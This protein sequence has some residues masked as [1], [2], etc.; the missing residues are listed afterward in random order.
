MNKSPPRFGGQQVDGRFLFELTG[1]APALNFI[2]TLDERR[3]GQVERLTSFSVLADWAVQAEVL[4][5]LEGASLTAD[6]ERDTVQA[7]RTLVAAKELRELLFEAAQPLAVGE[8]LT[9]AT[10]RRLDDWARDA[11]RRRHLVR[12]GA[13][14][15]W[16]WGDASQ[17][18]DVIL[19]RLVESATSIFV[20]EDLVR[21]LRICGGPGCAWVFLDFSRHQNR[22]WCDM[23]VCG[24]RAKSRRH[25]ERARMAALEDASADR[26]SCPR[27]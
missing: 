14:L 1:G 2:N 24:N 10:L 20:S 13:A 26:P 12:S 11:S 27:E 19:W 8:R 15:A 17:S 9:D 7:E 22:R 3:A 4:S 5:S 21:R 16:S 6:A 25:H 23:S 18:P